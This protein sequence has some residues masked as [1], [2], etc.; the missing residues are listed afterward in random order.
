MESSSKDRLLY[1]SELPPPVH[2]TWKHL[3]YTLTVGKKSPTTL[4]KDVSGHANTGQLLAIMGSSGAG[5]TTLLNALSHRIVT[6]GRGFRLTGHVMA[7][8]L[9]YSNIQVGQFSAYVMQDDILIETLTPRECFKFAVEMRFKYQEEDIDIWVQEVINLL[10]LEQCA[11]RRIGGARIKGISGGERKRVAIGI[12][13]LRRPSVLFLDEPTSGLDSQ[14]AFNVIKVLKRLCK[15]YGTTVICTIH[16]P[17]AETF[18]LFDRLMLMVQGQVAYQGDT[19]DAISFFSK[20]GMECPTYSNPAD[21]FLATLD[22]T[23]HNK[24]HTTQKTKAETITQFY[25][26]HH[27]DP[28]SRQDY[29]NAHNNHPI[30]TSNRATTPTRRFWLLTKRGFISTARHKMSWISIF[31]IRTTFLLLTLALYSDLGDNAR[32]RYFNVV[33]LLFYLVISEFFSG[34]TAVTARLPV[35][36]PV[37]VREHDG[38]LYTI[39]EYFFAKFLVDLPFQLGGVVY[40]NVI[41][42]YMLDLEHGGDRL[43]WWLFLFFLLNQTGISLGMFIGSVVSRTETAV[44]LMP[45]IVLPSM[46]FGGFYVNLQKLWV[47]IRWFS[48]TS[49]MRFAFEGL[50]IN[51]YKGVDAGLGFDPI[52]NMGFDSTRWAAAFILIGIVVGFRIIAFC[53]LVFNNSRVISSSNSDKKVPQGR[54]YALFSSHGTDKSENI[55]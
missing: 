5:K 16:Q 38:D 15:V 3:T 26:T 53:A 30:P 10:R 52:E 27:Q 21:F 24:S 55:N 14:N 4:L 6:N 37:F 39:G 22:I 48:Y 19:K 49:P 47:G 23:F 54:D 44:A 12:E 42:F 46:I 51:Q 32:L 9:P 34:I 41:C 28:Q 50:L 25:Q 31:V 29:I 1:S 20:A 8:G 11:D 18:H 35:D 13:L 40:F 36:K 33:G 43:I 2:M 17:N 45:I 7:N